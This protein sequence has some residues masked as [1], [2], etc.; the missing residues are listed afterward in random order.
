MV[1]E[2]MR[3]NGERSHTVSYFR[4]ISMAGKQTRK[5]LEKALFLDIRVAVDFLQSSLFAS[6]AQ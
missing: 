3:E 6:N 2:K 1:D 5:L 4:S